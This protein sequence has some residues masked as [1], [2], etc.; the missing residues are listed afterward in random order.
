MNTIKNMAL[1]PENFSESMSQMFDVLSELKFTPQEINLTNL[2]VEETFSFWEERMTNF[3]SPVNMSV[4]KRLGET[5]ISLRL[6]GNPYNPLAVTAE[7][8]DD[9]IF[10]ARLAILNANRDRISYTYKNGENIITIVAHR[11]S[12]KKKKLLYTILAMVLGISTGFLM[13]T[14]LPLETIQSIDLATDMVR[15]IFLQL[16]NMLVAPV[17][18]FS[19][20][21]GLSQMSD[22]NDAGRIGSRLALVTVLMMLTMS[23]LSMISGIFC[24]SEDLSFMRTSVAVDETVSEDKYFSF[25]NMLAEMFPENL[26]DPMR[27][28]NIMQVMFLSIFF[29]VLISRMKPIPTWINEGISS[30]RRVFTAALEIVV[31]AIP[32]VVFISMMS[33]AALSRPESLIQLGKLI[34][35]QGFGVI[36]AL[37]VS[38]MMVGLAGKTSPINFAKKAGSF[39]PIPFAAASSNGA[40]PATMKFATKN[41]GIS[42][43]LTSFVVP[44]GL[45]FNKQGNCFFFAMSTAMMMKVYGIELTTDTFITFFVT[46]FLMS[47]TKPSIPCAGI[48]CLTYLFDVMT[49]PAEAVTV[50]LGIEPIMALFIAVCNVV[51]NTAVA[52]VVARRENAVDLDIYNK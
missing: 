24:F 22:A 47:I 50:V 33:L 3:T 39:F 40:L 48:I 16:L 42:S 15:K 23:F 45:Q 18:F 8:S 2:L 32:L 1:T 29:G 49:I 41:L 4:Y 34:I 5:R 17:T 51:S 35:G 20:L 26:V 31:I 27:A 12:S 36:L 28:G 38:M 30:M 52:F 43:K 44:V 9:E 25:M 11:L 46:L 6:K 37:L 14:F 7:E 21:S 10:S 19:I 13:Q